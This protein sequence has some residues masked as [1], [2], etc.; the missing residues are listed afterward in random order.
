LATLDALVLDPELGRPL[1]DRL[2]GLRSARIGSYRVLC[3]IEGPLV[4]LRAIR[5]RGV[6]YGA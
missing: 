1:M 6:A 5:H 4:V 2:R 3:T